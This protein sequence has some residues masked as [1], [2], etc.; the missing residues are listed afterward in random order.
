[1]SIIIAINAIGM[2]PAKM[3]VVPSVEFVP[4]MIISPSVGAP[5]NEP[6]ATNCYTSAILIPPIITDNDK[7][8]SIILK[9]WLPVM[10][11]PLPAS[12]MLSSTSTIPVYVFLIIGS[13]EYKNTVTTTVVGPRPIANIRIASIAMAGTV[14]IMLAIVMIGHDKRLYF[15]IKS[16]WVY[17]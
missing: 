15:A 1:M 5:I 6:I 12:L 3:N 14:W 8:S 17:Q 2:A 10:P 16:Q 11:I 7:G 13:K 9:I 4:R